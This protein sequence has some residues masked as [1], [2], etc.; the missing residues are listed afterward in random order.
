MRK[1]A[2]DIKKMEIIAILNRK[3]GVGKTTTTI[4]LGKA[5][6]LL[7]KRVLLIDNDAQ[8]NLSEGLEVDINRKTIYH[9]YK[10]NEPLPI[11][12]IEENFH[13]VPSSSDLDSIQNELIDDFNRN[14]KLFKA[15]QPFKDQ[16]D[17]IL[18]DCPPSLGVYTANAL[19]TATRY[20]ITAQSGSSYSNSGVQDVKALIDRDVKAIV[21]PNIQCL[22]ILVTFFNPHTNISAA[23]VQ[24][25]ED[26][27]NGEVFSTRIRELT[28]LKE[29]PYLRQDIF[30]YAPT[31]G[32]A[33]DYRDLSK[34][35]I[36]RIG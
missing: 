22:G 27:Y 28:K 34:E 5:L 20:I 35:V 6:S 11:Q 8:A 10:D 12:I 7:G 29:A 23:I 9:C 31:S 19:T 15:I 30:V 36:Q 3:G 16:Y 2:P 13:I 14:Y 21:N 24:D 26:L 18:I 32:A 1:Q 17:F 33:D 25:L 4:N